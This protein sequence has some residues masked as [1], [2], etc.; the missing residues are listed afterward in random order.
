[1]GNAM[2]SPNKRIP[3][4]FLVFFLETNI[5]IIIGGFLAPNAVVGIYNL[6]LAPYRYT[7][8]YDSSSNGHAKQTLLPTT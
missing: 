6:G 7:S 2:K 5:I 4:S 3:G 1:M 8:G